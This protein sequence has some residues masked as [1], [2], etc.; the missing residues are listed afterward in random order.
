MNIVRKDF[1]DL[2]LTSY[3]VRLEISG[4]ESMLHILD[5]QL[6]V[7]LAVIDLCVE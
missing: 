5:A 6:S 4:D 7:E 2:Y 1:R 3:L